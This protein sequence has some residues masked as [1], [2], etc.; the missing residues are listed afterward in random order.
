MARQDRTVTGETGHTGREEHKRWLEQLTATQSLLN[1][2]RASESTQANRGQRRRKL[3]ELKRAIV[4]L[5][6]MIQDGEDGEDGGDGGNGGDG[7]DEG[8]GRG[9]LRDGVLSEHEKN[10]RRNIILSLL[11]ERDVLVQRLSQGILGE[12]GSVGGPVARPVPRETEETAIRSNAQLLQLQRA[13]M[14]DQ[15]EA[16]DHLERSV[17]RTKRIALGVYEET[18]LQNRLLEDF[19]EEVGMTS[20]DVY[21]VRQRVRRYLAQRGMCG[22]CGGSGV[23]WLFILALMLMIVLVVVLKVVS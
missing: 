8:D 9:G 6:R 14:E 13:L 22:C 12:P 16:L 23:G 15:D 2:A 21:N 5:Q 4:V 20:D 7:G 11:E 18:E 19:D 10:R 3:N 17:G 1:E